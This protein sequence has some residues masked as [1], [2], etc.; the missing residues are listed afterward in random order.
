MQDT[1]NLQAGSPT[2]FDMT[3]TLP[4]A[5]VRG[6]RFDIDLSG[7]P[8]PSGVTLTPAG[9]LSVSSTASGAI[10]AGVIF[11]YTEP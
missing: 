9:L 1:L 2:I 6:G 8:L 7:S 4:P 3:M 5:L 10:T 11:A